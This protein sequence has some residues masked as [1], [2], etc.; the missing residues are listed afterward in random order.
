VETLPGELARCMTPVEPI[1]IHNDFR[2]E[3]CPL[4]AS[5][6]IARRGSIA[7]ASP[8]LFSTHEISLRKT[9]ELWFCRRC[10]S[11]FTQNTIPESVTVGLY[12]CGGGKERWAAKP[13]EKSKHREILDVLDACFKENRCVLYIGCNTGELLDYAK[14][15][16]CGTCGVEFCVSSREVL[17]EKW[18]RSFSTLEEVP[19]G[20]D[21]VTA[22]DL[23]E[24]MYDVP[25]FLGTCR[26]KLRKD[27]RIVLLTG[28]ISSLGA[29]LAG[30]QWWYVSYP[31]H[32]VFPSRKYFNDYPGLKLEQWFRTYAS[33][34]YERPLRSLIYGFLYGMVRGSYA[35]LPS[36]GPDHELVILKNE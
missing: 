28:D 13:L 1:L 7:Y 20:Y 23:V 9:P 31:E 29:R 8:L 33:L 25:A 2:Y 24:H 5:P 4:C 21:V 26:K 18:H 10:D 35:A 6:D 19:D 32:I 34:E 36:P 16:G 30:P 15:K 17:A 14:Q 3:R 22:F 27:G 11:G 12:A